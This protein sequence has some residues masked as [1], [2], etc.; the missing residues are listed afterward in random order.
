M[1]FFRW[2]KANAMGIGLGLTALYIIL[3]IFILT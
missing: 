1:R 2:F 3:A